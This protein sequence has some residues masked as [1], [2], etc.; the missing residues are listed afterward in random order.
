M[1]IPALPHHEAERLATL[2]DL[3][4]VAALEIQGIDALEEWRANLHQH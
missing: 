4:R 3:A 1:K 2:R